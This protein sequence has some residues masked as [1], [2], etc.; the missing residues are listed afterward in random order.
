[1]EYK[2]LANLYD[3]L[4]LTTKRLEKTY[5]ISNFIKKIDQKD[6]EAFSL[7]VNG[8]I[9]PDWSDKKI[10]VAAKIVIKA[11]C[12]STAVSEFEVEKQWKK[13]GDLG[14]V[15]EDLI[16]KKKQS[17]LF[18][19]IITLN[20]IFKNLKKLSEISGNGSIDKKIDI[21]SEMLISSSPVEA[22]YIVRTVIENMRVG[23]GQG[24]LRDAIIWAYFGEIIELIY[25]EE[26][27][28]LD[29]DDEKRD[30]YSEYQNKVQH[31]LDLSNDFSLVINSIRE[32]GIKG[33]ENIKLKPGKPINAM[34]FKKAENVLE[35][36]KIVGSPAAFEYKYDGFRL[37]IHKTDKGIELYTRRLENVTEQF[38]DIIPV[39]KN[40]IDGNEFILDSE[41]VGYDPISKKYLPFQKIS[42]RI[43]RKY[44]IEE[45]S[46]NFPVEINIFDIMY[47][48]GKDYLN[49]DFKKRREILEKII[50][51]ENKKIVLTKMIVTDDE[52]EA[53]LFY[54]ES[55]KSGEEGIM[56]KALDGIYKP[57]SRVG[58]G[59]K[60]KPTLEPLD[61]V[62]VSAEWG[63]GKRKGWL[64]SFTLACFDENKEDFLEIGKVSTGLKEIESEGV[65][66]FKMTEVLKPFLKSK[67]GK[68]VEVEPRIIIEV[69]YEEIQKSINYSSGYALRFPRFLR[70]RDDKSLEEI[71][72]INDVEYLFNNQKNRGN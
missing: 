51:Q 22:K 4:N 23:I 35:A 44:D 50:K 68:N 26:K 38:P 46:K 41:I 39:I 2:K 29:L 58:Y 54:D 31:A 12:K 53:T 25:D 42:Q 72:N 13:I 66:F 56:A 34:L 21:I 32:N 65:S 30:L 10:G 67:E 64:S 20:E 60:I 11:I 43:R 45:V 8:K 59:V 37:Q 36:F 17:S 57:G 19:K 49:V 27:K 62:I 5:I 70:L 24:T 69:A 28:S 16:S 33:L 3:E 9:F 15:V 55:V 61:L 63:E 52:K 47:L 18:P 40:N 14:N 1:M 7:L 48:E 6:I 71:N